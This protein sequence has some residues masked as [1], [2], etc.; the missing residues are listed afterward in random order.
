MLHAIDGMRKVG[1]EISDE[2]V[3][4]GI[5]GVENLT[6]LRGRWTILNDYVK[7]VDLPFMIADTGHNIAGITYNMS[8]LRRLMKSR[9]E[10]KLRIVIGFVADKAI[11]KILKLM[12]V[13][14]VYYI[15]NAQIPR[16]LPAE[17]L[18]ERFIEAG[19]DGITYPDVRSAFDTALKE[20]TP[21]DIIFIGGS[22]FI[23]ADLLSSI[24]SREV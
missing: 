13:D 20:S 16:A 19:L 9:P 7:R 1:I 18:K 3:I 12:P 5:E 11:D 24:S 21:Q 10:G 4:K 22:T 2:N 23:V 6:G 15:T 17:Q 8:Q 14:A